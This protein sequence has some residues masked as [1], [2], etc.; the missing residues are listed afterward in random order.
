LSE[1]RNHFLGLAHD[2]WSTHSVKI[3]FKSI[4]DCYVM[5]GTLMPRAY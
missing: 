4:S 1:F 5:I 3:A 2:T